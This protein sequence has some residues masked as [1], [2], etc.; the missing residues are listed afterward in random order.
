MRS[1]NKRPSREGKRNKDATGLAVS[2]GILNRRTAQPTGGRAQPPVN[3]DWQ[4]WP[5]TSIEHESSKSA[6]GEHVPPVGGLGELRP[7]TETLDA[8]PPR[9]GQS[10]LNRPAFHRMP[11]P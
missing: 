8:P 10:F 11:L 7:S 1:L 4:S 6:G 5:T 2:Y 3:F 9:D